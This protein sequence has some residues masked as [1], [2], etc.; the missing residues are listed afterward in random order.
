MTGELIR[1]NAEITL[2]MP[3]S[4]HRRPAWDGE[5]AEKTGFA[6]WGAD[7]T[8]GRRILRENDMSD[9]PMFLFWAEK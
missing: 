3:A 1:E 2:S 6:S 5:L 9:A 7:E 4:D 8:L